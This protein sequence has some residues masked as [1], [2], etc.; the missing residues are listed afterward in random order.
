MEDNKIISSCL[1]GEK[2][3]FEMLIKK[4]QVPILHLAWRI[5]GD[6]DEAKDATQDTFVQVFSNLNRFDRGMSFK[7]WLYSI[8]YKRCLR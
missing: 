7:N 5:L 1:S 2:E 4:Y 6:K 3:A 8:T